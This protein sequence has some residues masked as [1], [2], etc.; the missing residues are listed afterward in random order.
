MLGYMGR[1]LAT[2][3]RSDPFVRGYAE[4]RSDLAHVRGVVWWDWHT[5]DPEAAEGHQV[6]WDAI[7]ALPALGKH[8]IFVREVP[9]E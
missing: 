7:K 4:A 6:D 1:R 3:D 8:R 9:G 5:R 2:A